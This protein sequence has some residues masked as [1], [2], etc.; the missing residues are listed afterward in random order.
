[1]L[2][3]MARQWLQH[4]PTRLTD[5][6]RSWTTLRHMYLNDRHLLS[7]AQGL[8]LTECTHVRTPEQGGLVSPDWGWV[9]AQTVEA[10]A[11]AA[12]L[13]GGDRALARVM[14]LVGCDKV[15]NERK[16]R[17]GCEAD[18]DVLQEKGSSAIREDHVEQEIPV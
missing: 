1:M 10:I 17:Q 2:A 12:Y 6:N 5:S 14:E 18:A 11:A 9:A 7:A 4:S 15:F 3:Y 8:G 16:N 13:D